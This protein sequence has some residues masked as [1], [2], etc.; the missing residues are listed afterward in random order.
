MGT[1]TIARA[2]PSASDFSARHAA[3]QGLRRSRGALRR[4]RTERAAL[5]GT[6]ER[7]VSIG[8]DTRKIPTTMLADDRRVLNLLRAERTAFH[9][10]LPHMPRLAP[11]IVGRRVHAAACIRWRHPPDVWAGC[12]RHGSALSVSDHGCFSS[13]PQQPRSRRDPNLRWYSPRRSHP[14][15]SASPS[16]TPLDSQAQTGWIPR[17]RVAGFLDTGRAVQ[18]EPAAW[19]EYDPGVPAPSTPPLR[20]R[21]KTAPALRPMPLL[22]LPEPF[23]HPDWLFEVKHDGFRAARPHRRTLL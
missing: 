5:A 23:D 8:C 16:A 10:L 14:F 13:R 11:H 1:T 20:V 7:G 19:C 17:A 9:G 15:A 21:P 2:I 22:R 4:S 12:E 3:K 18:L 6:R